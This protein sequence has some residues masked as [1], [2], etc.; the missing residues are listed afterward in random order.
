MATTLI[1][2]AA[3]KDLAAYAWPGGYPIMYI[4]RDGWREDTG[5]LTINEHDHSESSCCAKCAANVTSWPDMI[6]TG[7]YIHYEG[8]PEY[9]EWCNGM[10]ES[11]YGDPAADTLTKDSIDQT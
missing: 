7:S 1:I 5:E 2:D 3:R 11:A 6:V 4:A 10:T 9:C 8:R